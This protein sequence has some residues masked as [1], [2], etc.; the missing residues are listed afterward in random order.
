M[1]DS[2]FLNTRENAVLDTKFII[3]DL[4]SEKYNKSNYYFAKLFNRF[5]VFSYIDTCFEMFNSCGNNAII[6]DIEEYIRNQ[7]GSIE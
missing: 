6:S 5:N 7:G 2:L 4:F 1:F 3:L